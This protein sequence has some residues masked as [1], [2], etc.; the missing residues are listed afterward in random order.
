MS[1]KTFCILP[2]IHVSAGTDGSMRVCCSANGGYADSKNDLTYSDKVGAIKTDDGKISNLNTG[3][4]VESFNNSYMKNIRRQ[5]MAGEKP[6][7][8]QSCYKIE[9]VTKLS[10]RIIDNRF[11]EQKLNF[12]E[13][14]SQTSSDGSVKET[15]IL[16]F[17][18]RFGN[19][20]QLGCIMCSPH[21]STGWI[22]D[23]KNIYDKITIP[24]LKRNMEWNN[25]GKIDGSN[26]NWYK[27]NT[28]FWKDFY[29]QIPNTK[30]IF[31]AGGE[32]LIIDE[33][34]RV[35]EN[36]VDLGHSKNLEIRYNSNGVEWRDDLFDLWKEFKKID[37]HYSVDDIFQ[38]NEYI[39]YPSKWKRTEEVFHI[40]DQQTSDNVEVT[41]ACVVQLLNVYYIPDYIKWKL[42]KRFSK[43]NSYPKSMG[44]INIF[45]TNHPPHLNVKVLPKW[46]KQ[47]CREK[48]ESFY[49]WWEQNWKI[50]IPENTLSY[51]E[52][53]NHPAGIK[54]LQG[55]ISFMDSEDWSH[56]LPETKEFIELCDQSRGTNFYSTFP[57]MSDIFKSRL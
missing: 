37:F 44:G 35:L 38:R 24:S 14:L 39:R 49:I 34:Y 9:E 31:F 43:I 6:L 53:R 30:K 5:M 17:D 41:I 18:L 42:E 22:K 21:E 45:L 25:K 1:K 15:K 23:W 40:L 56:R 52:W 26:Y 7:S 57:E 19:K 54:K 27:K 11:W 47:K 50:G 8:C 32:P 10:K 28:R 55:I 33:H 16:Y 2:W 20:C 51:D 36:L 13:Y 46:F 4:F 3:N 29:D 12:E 48:Y